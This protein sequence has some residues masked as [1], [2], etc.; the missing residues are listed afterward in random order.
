MEKSYDSKLVAIIGGFSKG[1]ENTKAMLFRVAEIVGIT[2]R[3]AYAAF[4]EEYCSR[5][6]RKKLE[7]AARRK[8]ENDD[9]QLIRSIEAIISQLQ[10][11]D[12]EMYGPDIDAAREMLARYKD[13]ARTR[14]S[15]AVPQGVFDNSE[16]F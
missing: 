2:P 16:E 9:A 6:T 10:A 7:A 4:Y 14:V 13:F 15:M 12:P 1:R 3:E 5:T 11:V 8:T